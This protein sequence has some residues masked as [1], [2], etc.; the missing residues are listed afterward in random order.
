MSHWNDQARK[1]LRSEMDKRQM[2]APDLAEA[3]AEMGVQEMPNTLKNKIWRGQF[4]TAFLLQCMA[5]MGVTTLQLD[6]LL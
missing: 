5:A 2:Q 1:L 4:S 6:Q 3:L